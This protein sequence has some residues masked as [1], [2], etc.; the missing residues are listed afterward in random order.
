MEYRLSRV[1]KG[2]GPHRHPPLLAR[3]LPQ[4]RRPTIFFILS[5]CALCALWLFSSCLCGGQSIMQNKAN[6]PKAK[7]TLNPCC[8][9]HYGDIS[10]LRPRQNKANQSPGRARGGP[11]SNDQT[12]FQTRFSGA[13]NRSVQDYLWWKSRGVIAPSRAGGA[14]RPVQLRA[15]SQ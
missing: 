15:G 14:C 4:R 8:E 12:Q 10:S 11:I 6:L 13:K 1:E 7:M 3:F 2:S 9:R 5:L